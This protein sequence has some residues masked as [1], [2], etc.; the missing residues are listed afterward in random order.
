MIKDRRHLA[1]G[2]ALVE[3]SAPRPI[4]LEA[5]V[6]AAAAAAALSELQNPGMKRGKKKTDLTRVCVLSLI[7]SYPI[8]IS[9]RRSSSDFDVF[10]SWRPYYYYQ[11][12]SDSSDISHAVMTTL[13]VI[14]LSVVQ[15]FISQLP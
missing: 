3:L 6:A 5:V 15:L 9:A 8:N 12:D 11:P 7:V 10:Q 1:T 13:S 2:G 4:S 14:F